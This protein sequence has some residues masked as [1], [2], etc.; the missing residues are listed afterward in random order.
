MEVAT[1]I[2]TESTEEIVGFKS[3][4]DV[5]HFA[6]DDW[7]CMNMIISIN[8]FVKRTLT[9]ISCSFEFTNQHGVKALLK[10]QVTVE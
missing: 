1:L 2:P 6:A 8:E 7:Q 3:W 9:D 5:Y 10:L 4:D